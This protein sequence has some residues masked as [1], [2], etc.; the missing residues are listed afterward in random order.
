M[1]ET[2]E[3]NNTI[4]PGQDNPKFNYAIMSGGDPDTEITRIVWDGIS[5]IDVQSIF[6]PTAHLVLIGPA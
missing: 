3:P 6:G 5:P 1:Q 2:F 4:Y